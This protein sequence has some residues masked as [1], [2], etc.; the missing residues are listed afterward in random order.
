MKN[1]KKKEPS[2]AKLHP[3][4]STTRKQRGGEE[5][6]GASVREESDSKRKFLWKENMF[7]SA[8]KAT[9]L[10][11]N[12]TKIGWEQQA[13]IYGLLRVARLTHSSEY[14]VVVLRDGCAPSPNSHTDT[15]T[16]TF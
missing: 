15:H 8:S 5:E 1:K 4:L 9:Q 14:F 12:K 16:P 3:M 13:T 10:S 7:L 2:G 6:R 11:P